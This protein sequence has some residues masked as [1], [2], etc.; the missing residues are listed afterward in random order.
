[1]QDL[2]YKIKWTGYDTTCEPIT[3]LKGTVNQILKNYHVEH[4]LRIYKWML[5]GEKEN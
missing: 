1:M 3:D 4:G 5:R 2:Q